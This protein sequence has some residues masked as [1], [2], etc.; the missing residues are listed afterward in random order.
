MVT[1]IF[2]EVDFNGDFK[3]VFPRVSLWKI[4]DAPFG[5][6]RYNYLKTSFTK[7]PNCILIWSI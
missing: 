4:N 6:L 5:G 3:K 1:G 2:I 7:A